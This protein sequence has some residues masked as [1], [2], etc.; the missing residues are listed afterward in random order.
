MLV[1]YTHRPYLLYQLG[2]VHVI[3]EPLDVKLYHLRQMGEVHQ[4]LCFAYCVFHTSL[5]SKSVTIVTEF[6]LADWLHDLFDTLLYQAVPH[7]WD[8][9][10]SGGT[11]ALECLYV[12]PAE[13]GSRV[14]FL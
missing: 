6:G 11:V 13:A 14:C 12:S 8:A 7:T 4:V 9:K 2:V 1:V 3:K 5:R 10:R